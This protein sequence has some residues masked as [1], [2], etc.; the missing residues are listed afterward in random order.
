MPILEDRTF[1]YQVWNQPVFSFTVEQATEID[2]KKAHELLGVDTALTTYK[3]N[4]DAKK[5]VE[6]FAKVQYVTESHATEEPVIPEIESYLRN[7]SYHYI[8]ELDADGKILGG[9]WLQG[10]AQHSRWGISE[11]PDFLWYSTGPNTNSFGRSN[12]YVDYRKVKELLEKSRS[13][14]PDQPEDPAARFSAQVEPGAAIPDNDPAGVSSELT[15]EDAR[16]ATRVFINV[17]ITHTY[18]GDLEIELKKGDFAKVLRRKEGGSADDLRTQFEV[19]EL[20]GKPL[21]GAYTLIVRDLARIDTGKLVR[22]GVSAD[23]Q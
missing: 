6:V 7:D 12:P 4:P 5:F 17:D 22:W 11:Q 19:P 18:V 2:L 23:V 14:Q 21:Q 13:A 1:D 15:V 3:Y 10:R 8:L 20:N 16:V 9:E